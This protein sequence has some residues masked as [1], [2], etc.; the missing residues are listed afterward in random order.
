M[1][2]AGTVVNLAPGSRTKCVRCQPGARTQQVHQV[3][4][5]IPG[6]LISMPRTRKPYSG[7]A[8]AV[9]TAAG[10]WAVCSMS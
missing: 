4:Q 9:H 5:A 6:K 3:E 7:S 10:L 1:P 2:A 8:G